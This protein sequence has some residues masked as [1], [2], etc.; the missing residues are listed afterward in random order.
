LLRAI[1]REVL[2]SGNRE[3][4][5]EHFFTRKSLWLW[6]LRQH[7]RYRRNYPARFA[8]PENRH[9]NV[10]RLCSMQAT[11][12]WLGTLSASAAAVETS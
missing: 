12:S 10:V 4:L 2:W 5:Y 8:A 6:A 11:R 9:L 1:T 3:L 7:G